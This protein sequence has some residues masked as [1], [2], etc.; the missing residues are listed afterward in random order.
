MSFLSAWLISAIAVISILLLAF[1]AGL[2]FALGVQ[3]QITKSLQK[4]EAQIKTMEDENEK[5]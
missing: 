3:T 1:L 5:K 2:V 4:M